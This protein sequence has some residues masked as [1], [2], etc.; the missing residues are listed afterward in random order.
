MIFTARDDFLSRLAETPSM[1]RALENVTVLQAPGKEALRE[2][3]TLPLR[4]VGYDYDDPA[5]VS[6]MIDA[7]GGEGLGAA[8]AAV[9]RVAAVGTS[10]RDG[11]RLRR[12]DYDALG[13]VQGALASHADGALKRLDFQDIEIVRAAMLRLVSSDGTRRTVEQ[14]E[15]VEALG[16]RATHVLK[17]LSDARLLS[18][19][20]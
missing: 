3:M 8:A 13:G 5:L 20:Q 14:Q 2:I 15:L 7:A 18:A 16:P 4:A 11:K 9:H 10:G 1:R 17:S 12:R 19:A 6:D